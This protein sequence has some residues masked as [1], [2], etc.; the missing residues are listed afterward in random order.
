[1]ITEVFT[2]TTYGVDAFIVRVETH[3][4]N[5]LFSFAIVGLPDNAVKESKEYCKPCA[6]GH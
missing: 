2:A 5:T 4:D 1:M 6:G 3:I